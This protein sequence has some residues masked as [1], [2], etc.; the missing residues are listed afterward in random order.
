MP[1]EHFHRDGSYSHTTREHP[2][3]SIGYGGLPLHYADAPTL[4][5]YN[6][7]HQG[8]A[9]RAIPATYGEAVAA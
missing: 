1:V 4:H 6:P 8:D 7:T 9:Y 2:V 5:T 3:A